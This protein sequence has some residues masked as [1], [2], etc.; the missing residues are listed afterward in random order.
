MRGFDTQMHA[1]ESLGKAARH[2][3]ECDGAERGKVEGRC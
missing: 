2:C 1:V 3:G